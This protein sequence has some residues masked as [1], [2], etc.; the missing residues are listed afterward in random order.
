MPWKQQG[1]SGAFMKGG[2]S[3]DPQLVV[4]QANAIVNAREDKISF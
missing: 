4:W 1:L 3:G 2:Y